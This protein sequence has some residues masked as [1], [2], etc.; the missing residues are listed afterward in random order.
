VSRRKKSAYADLTLDELNDI[1]HVTPVSTGRFRD[2]LAEVDRRTA[3]DE[4]DLGVYPNPDDVLLDESDYPEPPPVDPD[5]EPTSLRKLRFDR[6]ML[7]QDSLQGALARREAM[8]EMISRHFLSLRTDH[9]DAFNTNGR[10][11]P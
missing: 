8:Q 10:V 4:D 5:A 9:P 1:L 6:A 11:A 2:V 3:A 7:D